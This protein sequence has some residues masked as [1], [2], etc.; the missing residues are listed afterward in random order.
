M[1]ALMLSCDLPR[2]LNYF[3][4]HCYLQFGIQLNIQQHCFVLFWRNYS[5]T[6]PSQVWHLTEQCNTL[7]EKCTFV[8]YSSL[9]NWAHRYLWLT[10]TG[11]RACHPSNLEYIGS[12]AIWTPW[13]RLLWH[14]QGLNVLF[15]N[16]RTETFLLHHSWAWLLFLHGFKLALGYC[17]FVKIYQL[18]D[19]LSCLFPSVWMNVSVMPCNS[20]QGLPWIRSRTIMT[21]TKINQ[22]LKVNYWSNSYFRFL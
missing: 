16:D 5:K 15:L 13:H 8:G 4:N 6:W 2:S 12:F 14:H 18:I 7:E 21:V 1:S 19:W 10:L 17:P 3:L 9:H 22:L 11:N 20:N